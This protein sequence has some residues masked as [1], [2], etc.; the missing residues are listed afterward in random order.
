MLEGIAHA[1]VFAS[2]GSKRWDTC[3]PE[4]VLQAAGGLLTDIS[5]NF[6]SYDKNTNYQNTNGVL[7]TAKKE[8][9]C[10]Y[11]NLL[12]DSIKQSLK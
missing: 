3:A 11:L 9:H 1:Y 10:R 12:P 6:Y 4:A 8:D 2:K 7:A 5:G